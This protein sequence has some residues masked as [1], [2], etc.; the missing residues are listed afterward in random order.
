MIVDPLVGMS[1]VSDNYDISRRCSVYADNS[2]ER[3]WTKAWF[4]DRDKGEPSIPITKA[5]AI[6]F[7]HQ[8]VTRDQWLSRFYP[9][10]MDAV[11]QSIESTRRQLLGI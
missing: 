11:V 3:W 2:G 9:K 6:A 4:N 7:I 5:L 10:Q 1:V 8:Q